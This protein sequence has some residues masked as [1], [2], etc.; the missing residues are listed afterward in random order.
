MISY[1]VLLVY[2]KKMQGHPVAV[3]LY[4]EVYGSYIN[5]YLEPEK[6][7]PAQIILQ[8]VSMS[9]ISGY[10]YISCCDKKPT[11]IYIV[12]TKVVL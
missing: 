1:E 11:S 12:I 2:C 4:N 5:S 3:V 7:N 9:G 6:C 10:Y 8:S